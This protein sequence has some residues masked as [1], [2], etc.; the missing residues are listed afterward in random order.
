ELTIETGSVDAFD[1]VRNLVDVCERLDD[2]EAAAEWCDRA[3]SFA[4]DTGQED[5]REEFAARLESLRTKL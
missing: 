5:A 1:A 4:E 2:L 3:V